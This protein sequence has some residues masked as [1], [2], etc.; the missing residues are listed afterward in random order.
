MTV[1]PYLPI[2]PDALRGIV[3]MK[4]GAV[5]RRAKESHG[6]QIDVDP[7][8][9]EAIAERCREVE[10]G[11]R[12][13]EHILRANVMPMLSR[14]ILEDL[15]VREEGKLHLRLEAGGPLG[16]QCVTV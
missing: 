16:I 3:E 1:I 10:S 9:L 12:N 14:V 8:V 5:V 11:A 6:V 2:Q 7:A 13:V 15:A 4:L